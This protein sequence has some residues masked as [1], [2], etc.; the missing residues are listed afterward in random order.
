MNKK[1][2]P[3]GGL[4]RRAQNQ[5][6][7]KV[8]SVSHDESVLQQ[9]RFWMRAVTW[10]LIGTTA[11]AVGW[12]TIARTEEIVVAQGK[13]EPLGDV[14]EI[15]VPVGGIARDILIKGGDRVSKGQI[16]IQL[17]TEASSEQ[18]NSL[19]A[20]LT[21][22]Q[23]Q[24]KLK[25]EEQQGTL[26][27]SREQVAT[28]RDNLALEQKILSRFEFLSAQ[29]ASSELQYL[30]QRNKVRELRG[31]VTKEKLD[32]ARQQSILNQDIE[33]LNSQLAQ[34]KARLTEAKVTLK[35]QS[36]RSPVDGV[37]FDLKP[38]TPGFVAQS[39]EPVLKIVPFNNLEADVEIPSNKIG[40]VRKGMSVDISIDSFPATDFGVL[41]G[42]VTSIGSDA[43][44][45]DQQKQRQEYHFPATIELDSQQ[46]KLKNGTTLPLQV[47]MSLTANIKLRSVSY[48]QLL[49]G[50]FQSKTDSLRQL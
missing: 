25:L 27:L 8:S 22:K 37:V 13:L 24:L 44:P 15:Q 7:Q 2:N 41:E 36:L 32:G 16:L 18:V 40:F 45:P 12:L 3:V 28:T 1:P 34:L 47:G 11:F 38:T 23:Q 19:E 50:Q 29:G 17:D 20:Q 35:Y 42:K 5:L 14:K 26:D 46:L 21:K 48:L 33:Q 43:L 9:S 31:R 6:E 39:S 4:I 30:Q 10:S 49:L